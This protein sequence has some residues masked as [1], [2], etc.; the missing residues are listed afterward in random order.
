MSVPIERLPV[1]FGKTL[2]ELR[3]DR[4][5]SQEA[6]AKAAAL[7]PGAVGAMELGEREPTLTEFIC[8][9][10]AVRTPPA[11]L[12]MHVIGV[13]RRDPSD[14]GLYKSRASDTAWLYRLGYEHQ[15]GDFRERE[16]PYYS[17]AEATHAAGTL[18]AQRHTRGVAL[19]DTVCVYVRID[20]LS[21]RPDI[22][23]GKETP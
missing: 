4:K 12:L 20:S 22:A 5:L 3:I 18:N 23:S 15:P 17:V 9:A 7:S 11:I 16:R 13:W 8:I 19:L 21:L 14:A 2:R 10:D 1:A 6:V